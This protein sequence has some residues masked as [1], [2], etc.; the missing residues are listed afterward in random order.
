M[1]APPLEPQA[2][3]TGLAP[4]V[5]TAARDVRKKAFAKADM[6]MAGLYADTRNEERCRERKCRKGRGGEISK[7]DAATLNSTSSSNNVPCCCGGG[8]DEG[9]KYCWLYLH[10]LHFCL[11]HYSCSCRTVLIPIIYITRAHTVSVMCLSTT[12]KWSCSYIIH[13]LFS[14]IYCI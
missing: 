10:C 11:V 12:S 1:R 6:T 3:W 2:F 7:I 13:L 14:H 8:G 4:L 9:Q 5:L